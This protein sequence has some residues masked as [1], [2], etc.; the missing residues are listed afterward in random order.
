[1]KTIGIVGGI[2]SG[3]T[4]VARRF[5]DLGSG[6][7]VV[8]DIVHEVLEYPEVVDQ[9]TSRFR[10]YDYH[11]TRVAKFNRVRLANIFLKHPVELDWVE[12]LTLP[13]VEDALISKLDRYISDIPA[14]ILDCPLLFEAKWDKLCDFVLYIEAPY[15]VRKVRYLQ[16]SKTNKAEVF[17]FL[18]ERQWST[19][20]KRNY[21]DYV[22]ATMNDNYPAAVEG[23]WKMIVEKQLK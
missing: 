12:K 3:K 9:I 19:A 18:E 15:A 17:D 1:M 6:L 23:F 20:K 11:H 10:K 2:C 13:L 5:K 16:R 7:I 22:I 14:V 8:D 21:S 4:S